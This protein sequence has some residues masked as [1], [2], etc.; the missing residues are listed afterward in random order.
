MA[1]IFSCMKELKVKP[2]L[3]CYAAFLECL[4]RQEAI[5]YQEGQKILHEITSEVCC[6]DLNEVLHCF[7]NR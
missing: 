1:D 7:S 6:T 4:G 2:N 3:Q 5:D